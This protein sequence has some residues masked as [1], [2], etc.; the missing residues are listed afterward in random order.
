MPGV[1]G[2]RCEWIADANVHTCGRYLPY[3][4][5]Q[6]RFLLDMLELATVQSV[7]NCRHESTHFKDKGGM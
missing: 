7:P 6:Y 5:P 1:W 3:T 2:M 4:P